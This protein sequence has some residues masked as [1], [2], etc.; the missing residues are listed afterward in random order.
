MIERPEIDRGTDHGHI[1]TPPPTGT[2]RTSGIKHSYLQVSRV[3]ICQMRGEVLSDFYH[4]PSLSRAHLQQN[5][6]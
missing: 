6:E 3:K 2:G 1:D 4:I 5:K